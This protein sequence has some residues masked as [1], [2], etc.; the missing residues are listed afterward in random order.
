M[1]SSRNLTIAVILAYLLLTIL[2]IIPVQADVLVPTDTRIC[3]DQNGSP[4]NGSVQF[5]VNCYGYRMYPGKTPVVHDNSTNVTEE[6]VFSYS[7]SCPGYGCVI[8][9]PFYLNYRQI[10]RCDLEGVTANRSF[11]IPAFSDTPLP[12]C[13][14]IRPFEMMKDDNEYYNTTPEYRDCMNE[15]YREGDLC[16]RFLAECNPVNDPDCGNRMI[17]NRYYKNTPESR[18][19]REAADK[20]GLA[21]D[22]YLKKV[23]PSSMTMWIDNG[24]G[25]EEPAMRICEQHFSIPSQDTGNSTLNSGHDIPG[26]SQ[27]SPVESLYCSILSLV[28]AAC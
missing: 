4:Y 14:L 17:D 9:E 8:Y 20:K 22:I 23:D 3:F 6:I 13:T 19:C 1:K 18:A 27:K 7:A 28:G 16:N 10:E 26:V 21:C 11:S 5:T 25:R 24:T 2:L 15:S 12:D